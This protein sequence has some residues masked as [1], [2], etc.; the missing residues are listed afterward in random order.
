MKIFISKGGTQ[1][2]PYSLP[3]LK[4][5]IKKGNITTADLA[6][7]DGKNWTTVAQIPGLLE[8]TP[9]PPP[10]PIEKPA[11]PAQKPKKKRTFLS[12]CLT[13][14]VVIFLIGVISATCSGPGS[15]SGNNQNNDHNKTPEE[16]RKEKLK[17][18]FSSWDGSHRGVEKHIKSIMHDPDSYDHVK[19]R[20]IDEGD[21]LIIST[22]FRGKNAFGGVVLN[23]YTAKVD[24]QGNVLQISRQ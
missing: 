1:Y 6:C 16:L 13:I 15:S 21:H 11:V 3:Q 14:I 22:S 19:T 5:F 10:L 2:G 7:Y 18:Q 8:K 20:Y 17:E 9:P 4:E 12:G 24:L 23:R